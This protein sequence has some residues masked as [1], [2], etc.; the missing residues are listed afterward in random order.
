MMACKLAPSKSEA[1]RLVTQ[2]GVTVD[3][4][5]ATLDTRVAEAALVNGVK[6][7]KGKKVYHKALLKA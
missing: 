6:I 4:E 3:G 1:R 7:R 2:G 5:K